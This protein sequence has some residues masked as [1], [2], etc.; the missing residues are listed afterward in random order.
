MEL[1]KILTLCMALN[2]AGAMQANPVTNYIEP[3]VAPE[4]TSP[5]P[6]VQNHEII[7]ESIIPLLT[8]SPTLVP[9][10]DITPN[11][12]YK[13]IKPGTKGEEVKELQA[14][15]L[16]LGYYKGNLD[17]SY[18][19][20]TVEAVRTF[21]KYHGLAADGYAGKETLTILFEYEKVINL[22]KPLEN[23]NENNN[24][25]EEFKSNN[26]F[27]EDIIGHTYTL[28]SKD[29]KIEFSEL[30]KYTLNETKEDI[31]LLFAYGNID[32][33]FLSLNTVSK[34][35]EQD[36][37]NNSLTW[38]LNGNNYNINLNNI[39][40]SNNG[41]IEYAIDKN[42]KIELININSQ[43][44]INA[45]TLQPLFGIKYDL[46]RQNKIIKLEKQE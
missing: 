8:P 45:L 29:K 22:N 30:L 10:P 40:L 46:D 1:L 16:E 39:D 27:P 44:Y 28:L 31:A 24:I 9:K 12:N 23:K 37:T 15:L 41:I 6:F 34:I 32:N 5:V 19:P 17:S 14:K 7:E 35:L 38:E 18:G 11:I 20:Q 13:L 25:A 2:Y 26:N 36:F 3:S 43:I 42:L 4:L 21:Q 33:I